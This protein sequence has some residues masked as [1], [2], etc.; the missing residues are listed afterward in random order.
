MSR[1]LRARGCAAWILTAGLTMNSNAQADALSAVQVLREG[2]C[3]GLMPAAAPLRHSPV[4]DRAAEKWAHGLAL[5]AAAQSSGYPADVIAGL[6]V[7]G[8]DTDMIS[9]LR[10]ASCHSVA[11]RDLQD[12]GMYR[13]G[14]D[15]WL[16]LSSRNTLPD[17]SQAPALAVRALELVNQARA[18]GTRCG[19]RSFAPTS[20]VTLSATLGTVAFGHAADMAEHDYF[21]HEDLSGHS[22][23]QRVRA[24]GYQENLVGENIAYGPKSIDEVVQGW[25]D[26]PDH[27]ENIMDPRFSQMGIAYAPGQLARHGLYWVQLLAAPRPVVSPASRMAQSYAPSER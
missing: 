15:N 5:S 9:M 24:A 22:P 26:S 11:S 16:V 8:S 19:Q 7:S 1:L 21:E 10:R 18:S 4:L 23:A 25:L 27:C 3:G 17:R 6:R 14:S 2:G 12:I 20:P 13:R